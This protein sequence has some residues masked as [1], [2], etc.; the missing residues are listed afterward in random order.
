[1]ITINNNNF[2][3][4]LSIIWLYSRMFIYFW[5]SGAE[6]CQFIDCSSLLSADQGGAYSFID[7]V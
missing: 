5:K 6:I 2:V 1:M 4:Y 3:T 7:I